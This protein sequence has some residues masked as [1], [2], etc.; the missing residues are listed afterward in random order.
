MFCPG[1]PSVILSF[2]GKTKHGALELEAITKSFEPQLPADP[3]S[4]YL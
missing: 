1:L 2:R 4:S 3:L